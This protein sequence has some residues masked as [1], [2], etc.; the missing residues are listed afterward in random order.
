M[1]HEEIKRENR[2]RA[3]ECALKLFYKNGIVNTTI[4]AIAK[5]ARLS[6]T[7]IY[8]YFKDKDTLVLHVAE[9]YSSNLFNKVVEYLRTTD[10]ENVNG[11][12]KYIII[13]DYIIH[14]AKEDKRFISFN[15]EL[16]NYINSIKVKHK[17]RNTAMPETDKLEGFV[18]SAIQ[19][20][21]DDKSIRD[22][23]TARDIFAFSSSTILD[24]LERAM[25][26]YSTYADESAAFPIETAQRIK[27]LLVYFIKNKQEK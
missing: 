17:N 9:F 3:L 21:L 4:S 7:P 22:D 11:L 2:Q 25:N 23:I 16:S 6:N 20:G 13:T 8:Q 15:F 19:K 1:T 18:V 5:K 14:L 24:S 26:Q 27:E 10:F 12:S